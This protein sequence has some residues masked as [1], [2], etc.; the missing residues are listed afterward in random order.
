MYALTGL[1]FLLA[2]FQ[3]GIRCIT[4]M[5]SLSNTGCMLFLIS[6]QQSCPSRCICIDT[7]MVALKNPLME[8]VKDGGVLKLSS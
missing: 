8:S 3:R 4:R 5:H 7:C 6:K 2:G 1:P